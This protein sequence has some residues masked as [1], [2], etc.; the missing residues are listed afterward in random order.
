[1]GWNQKRR[2]VCNGSQGGDSDSTVSSQAGGSVALAVVV[3]FVIV[4]VAGAGITFSSVV[5]IS[6]WLR[7]LVGGEILNLARS[8]QPAGTVGSG[9]LGSNLCLELGTLTLA[10]TVCANG[11]T[12]ARADPGI[13]FTDQLF[14]SCV[15]FPEFA[16]SV[17][18]GSNVGGKKDGNSEAHFQIFFNY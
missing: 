15:V 8:S 10:G 16:T 11:M 6:R 17:V 14:S 18:F 5:S 1:M 13:W 12:L 4:V 7:R 3:T 2:S 9:G